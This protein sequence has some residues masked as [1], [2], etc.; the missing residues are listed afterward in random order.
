MRTRSM[1]C[2]WP[3]AD[4]RSA[5]ACS[6]S[7]WRPELAPAKKPARLWE[8]KRPVAENARA[9]LPTLLREYFQAGRELVA[10]RPAP[11]DLHAFRLRTKRLRYTL[12][13]F[14]P[15]YGARLD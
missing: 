15:V 14:A 2:A 13:L 5:R 6:R 11:A 1:T 7:S 8:E 9:H 4:L 3:S 12:E 10:A